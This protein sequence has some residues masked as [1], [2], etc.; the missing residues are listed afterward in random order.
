MKKMFIVLTSALL[1]GSGLYSMEKAV[2]IPA[3]ATQEAEYGQAVVNNSIWDRSTG[4]L[5]FKV[6]EAAQGQVYTKSEGNWFVGD[7]RNV[8]AAARVED[9]S[10]VR[11]LNEIV[12]AK[13]QTAPMEVVAQQPAQPENTVVLKLDERGDVKVNQYFNFDGEL[14]KVV[15][16]KGAA[17]FALGRDGLSYVQAHPYRTAGHVAEGLYLVGA[18]VAIPAT[19]GVSYVAGAAAPL[20]T[21]LTLR[22]GRQALRHVS[23]TGRTMVEKAGKIKRESCSLQ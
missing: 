23:N 18:I 12:A 21:D 5:T 16:T 6:S 20:V 1:V 22:H 3:P 15:R 4:L 8:A 19:G 2:E 10:T 17:V 9:E 7:T 13:E 11:L 14:F